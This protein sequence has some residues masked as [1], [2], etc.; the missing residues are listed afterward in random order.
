MRIKQIIL[1]TGILCFSNYNLF[2]IK[3]PKAEWPV[4]GQVINQIDPM[5]LWKYSDKPNIQ[6]EIKIARDKDFKMDV[7]IIKTIKPNL[8]LTVP[9]LKRGLSYFWTIRAE[10]MD[11]SGNKKVSD[12]SHLQKKDSKS[13]LFKVSENAQGYTGFKPK[14]VYPIS[15]LEIGSLQPEFVWEFPEHQD[16]DFMVM[17]NKGEFIPPVYNQINYRLVISTSPDFKS[18]SKEFKILVNNRNLILSIPC[19]LPGTKYYW[20]VKASF[21]NPIVDKDIETDWAITDPISGDFYSFSI[22][23]D[24]IGSFSFEEGL[25]E[26]I[27]DH[28]KLASVEKIT[29]S[30]GNSFSPAISMD[31]QKLAFCSDG[32]GQIEIFVKN[33]NERRGGEMRKTISNK[34]QKNLNPF[35]LNN[36]TEL[37]FYS[38]R[39]RDDVWHLFTSNRG[40]GLTIRTNGMGMKENLDKF[41]LYG[42][43]SI[44]GKL[45]YTVKFEESQPY[46]IYM[47]DSDDGSITQLRPGILPDIRDDNK[48]VYCSDETGNFEI[49]LVD[50]EGRSVFNQTIITSDPA[51][52]YDPAFSPDQTRI[53]FTSNHSGNSDIWIMDVNGTNVRQLTFHPLVDRRPQW[54]DNETIVF[55]SNRFINGQGEPVY[56]IYRMNVTR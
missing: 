9:F 29:S 47:L 22:N 43:C 18:N 17:N 16:A 30:K 44:T 23:K 1:I 5:F 53:A 6:Y 55:Q 36:D 14:P 27:F 15:N 8:K 48:V 35:F 46:Y 12:W 26:E 28:Y 51:A 42:S 41:N 7:I 10:Y 45:I 34:N 50:L 32:L 39:Y 19:L 37:A 13:Y 54:A 40:T 24:A 49:F 25:K 20:K 38:N 52:D 21:F 56:D 4:N 3:G 33:L 11:G 31:G 2:A